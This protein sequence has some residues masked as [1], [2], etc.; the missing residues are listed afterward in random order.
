[1]QSAD[2]PETGFAKHTQYSLDDGLTWHNIENSIRICFAEVA[3]DDDGFHD[4]HLTATS[5]GIILDLWEQREEGVCLATNSFLVDDLVELAVDPSTDGLFDHCFDDDSDDTDDSGCGCGDDSTDEDEECDGDCANCDVDC[6]TSDSGGCEVT[7][8]CDG[9]C[10][11]CN[12]VSL[13]DTEDDGN[14]TWN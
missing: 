12:L 13:D 14:I 9:D 10:A 3:E 6:D 8:E 4:L 2:N 7:H 11:N 1:M 5:E